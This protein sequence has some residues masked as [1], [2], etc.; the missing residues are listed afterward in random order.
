M[1]EPRRSPRPTLTCTRSSASSSWVAALPTWQLGSSTD[2]L[3]D[4]GR[5][6]PGLGQDLRRVLACARRRRAIG[7]AL[8]VER[9][10]R[11]D[12]HVPAELPAGSR[13]PPSARRARPRRRRAPPSPDAGP[14]QAL[15]PVRRRMLGEP[16]GDRRRQEIGDSPI[17]GVARESRVRRELRQAEHVAE[18]AEKTVVRGGDHQLTVGGRKDAVWRDQREVVAVPAGRAPGRGCFRQLVRDAA[19]APSRRARRRVRRR[20]RSAPAAARRR[21]RRA[22]PRS[23]CRGRRARGARAHAGRSGSPVTLM[24][25]A[26]AWISGS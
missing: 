2:Q 18:R 25:P 7:R 11:P 10:G 14:A 9:H 12:G 16:T 5:A 19:R 21:R 24:I 20:G 1:P 3:G 4:L 23:P 8:A 15:D 13:A 22:Q 26:A 6:E 17:A